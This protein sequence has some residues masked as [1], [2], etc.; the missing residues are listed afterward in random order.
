MTNRREN[1][2]LQAFS[3]FQIRILDVNFD[4]SRDGPD[5]RSNSS[6]LYSLDLSSSHNVIPGSGI[7]H[8]FGRSKEI[9]I[10][11]ESK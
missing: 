2:T 7:C 11:S 9:E 10:T 8:Q 1:Y 5:V 3:S 6:D 4:V